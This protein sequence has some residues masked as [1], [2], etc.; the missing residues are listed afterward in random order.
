MTRASRTR[1]SVW[2]VSDKHP[3]IPLSVSS[4]SSVAIISIIMIASALHFLVG[5][6]LSGYNAS[7][8]DSDELRG[9]S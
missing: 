6:S 2:K 4:L 8:S 7:D 5:N 1:T 3:G 9:D